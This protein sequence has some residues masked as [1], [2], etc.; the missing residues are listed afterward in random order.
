HTRFSRDWS[1]DVCSSDLR[2]TNERLRAGG[3]RVDR[4][5]NCGSRFSW[6]LDVWNFV[7]SAKRLRACSRMAKPRDLAP[8]PHSCGQIDQP[9]RSEERRVG[10]ERNWRRLA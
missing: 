2:L 9:D 4:L 8:F 5:E 6:D 7:S 1:S 10:K 3:L